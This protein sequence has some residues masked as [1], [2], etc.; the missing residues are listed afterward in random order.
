MKKGWKMIAIGDILNDVQGEAAME[1]VRR[2]KSPQEA[3]DLL[4]AYFE[5]IKDQLVG[6]GVLPQ[7]LAYAFYHAYVAY[8]K[9]DDYI[10]NN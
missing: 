2:A 6:K 1:I 9:V 5:S 10:R 8:A 4:K 7:Y 3:T